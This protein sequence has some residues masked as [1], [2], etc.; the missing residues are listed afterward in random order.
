MLCVARA[1]HVLCCIHSF[2]VGP[3]FQPVH[4]ELLRAARRPTVRV[5]RRAGRWCRPH[6]DR[7]GHVP[8]PVQF[9]RHDLAQFRHLLGDAA[10][11]VRRHH[12]LPVS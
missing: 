8:V 4:G 9:R 5:Q 1:R 3:T 11:E 6:L 10:D 2:N 7:P 12:A